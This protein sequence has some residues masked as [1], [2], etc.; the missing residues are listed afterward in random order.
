MT[1]TLL[2][3]RPALLRFVYWRPANMT[4]NAMVTYATHP[5]DKRMCK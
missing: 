4:A 5:A 3:T 2:L 1:I